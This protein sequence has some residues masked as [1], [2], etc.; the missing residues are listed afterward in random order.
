MKFLFGNTFWLGRRVN[1]SI[2]SITMNYGVIISVDF[3][4]VGVN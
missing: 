2:K 4:V 3:I 1:D